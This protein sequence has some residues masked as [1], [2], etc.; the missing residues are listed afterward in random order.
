MTLAV[1]QIVRAD[2]DQPNHVRITG[3]NHEII[4]AGENLTGEDDAKN[5][6]LAIAEMFLHA[7]YIVGSGDPLVWHI[8]G[9]TRRGPGPTLEYVDKRAGVEVPD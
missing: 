2:G 1:F 9:Q 8:T 6:V 3:G 4:V 7:P 5:A